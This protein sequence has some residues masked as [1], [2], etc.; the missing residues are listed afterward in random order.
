MPGLWRAP[1][2]V[3]RV[4]AT[5]ALPG[6]KSMTNR[7]LLLAALADR[8]SLV[9]RPLRARDTELMARALRALGTG[10]VER[11]A[12]WAVAPAALATPADVD[13][14]L[15]GTV[16][17][18]VPPV[19]ALAGGPVRFDGDPRARERPIG[20]L[21]GALRALGVA[22][23]DGGRA[24][25][26]ITVLGA[27]AVRG[28]TVHID[29]SAS[30]QFVSALLLAGARYDR[31]VAVVHRGPPVPSRPHISMSVTMLRDAGVS[32]DDCEPDRWIVTPGVIRAR[33]I[34]V[35]PD[36]SNAAP[37]L[38]AA[39]VTGGTVRMPG[40]PVRTTQPGSALPPLLAEMGAR[41]DRSGDTLTVSGGA[42]IGGL[43]A[44][45]RDE[46]ELAPVLAAL[47]ALADGP[48]RLS[49]LAHMRGH[50]TDRLAALTRELAVLGAGV[51]Q[52]DDGLAI[53]PKPLHGGHFSTY[54]DHRMAQAGAVLGL[55]VDG[56]EVEDIAATD[57]TL[58]DF[59]GMWVAML[60]DAATRTPEPA[61]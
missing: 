24:S 22:V 50:E 37:F 15:A 21:L 13:V 2:A 38:A 14:G 20:P 36:L 59:P 61:R 34:D 23:D 56:V 29:A 25:L 41:I 26:P 39:L 11:G 5:V 6:S 48:S 42:R 52:T 32:V 40:W 3:D 43:R 27:G 19:A 60:G 31:G 57:K 44:D 28:G 1:Y 4:D 47:C 10:I 53:I 46:S 8:P 30:S 35:E 33:D 7:A 12:D 18:F 45:L 58:P 54:A 17:R 51:A 9:R 55:A 49:G 16:M